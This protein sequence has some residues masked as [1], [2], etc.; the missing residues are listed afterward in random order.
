MR[1][2]PDTYSPVWCPKR[3]LKNRKDEGSGSSHEP[4]QQLCY[5]CL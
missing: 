5:G 2:L 4:E 3:K 1:E